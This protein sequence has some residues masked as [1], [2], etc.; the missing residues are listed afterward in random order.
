MKYLLITIIKK[1]FFSLRNAI[2]YPTK[3]SLFISTTIF[4]IIFI[5]V[6]TIQYK[7]SF[8]NQEITKLN[9]EIEKE[10]NEFKIINAEYELLTSNERIAKLYDLYLKEYFES[11]NKD[12]Y[13][14]VEQL[15]VNN[16]AYE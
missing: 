9:F 13:I 16:R 7:I 6:Y 2:I 12:K 1:I 3:F 14:Y 5:L 11:K 15:D 4:A 10:E 8:N